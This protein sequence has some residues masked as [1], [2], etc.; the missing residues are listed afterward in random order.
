MVVWSITA[1]SLS[2]P[3][4]QGELTVVCL[5]SRLRLE[6]TAVIDQATVTVRM[7]MPETP[8]DYDFMFHLQS[9]M[10]P[11]QGD[12]L[13]LRVTVR[14][15]EAGCGRCSRVTRGLFLY[16]CRTCNIQPL[17]VACA[18]ACS[19]AVHTMESVSRPQPVGPPQPPREA[20]APPLQAPP[21]LQ[22]ATPSFDASSAISGSSSVPRSTGISFDSASTGAFFNAESGKCS[23]SDSGKF[24]G[25]RSTYSGE[26]CRQF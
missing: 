9:G 10:R 4:S 5:D 15:A 3:D 18:F 21:L 20:Q 17:C 23:P 25:T 1:V 12:P 8:G 7:H 11:L 2:G 24:S 6:G 22:P 13:P 19:R 14:A 16:H 26:R